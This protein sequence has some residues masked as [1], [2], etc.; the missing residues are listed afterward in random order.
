MS[1]TISPN[2]EVDAFAAA[3]RPTPAPQASGRPDV[4]AELVAKLQAQAAAEIALASATEKTAAA[5]LLA[6]AAAEA[7]TKIGEERARLLE[8]ERSLREQLADAQREAA[9]GQSAGG[10]RAL[11]IN[12]EIAG[13]E[14]MLAELQKDAP[15]IKSL[16]A[17]NRRRRVRRKSLE[18]SRG[19]HH[20]DERRGCRGARYGRRIR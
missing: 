11:K 16:Y 3:R 20:Q 8:Q 18:G 17:R 6:K 15:Q 19:V 10:E 7:E 9:S 5:S 4:V 12:A 1:F 13:L 14:K 2:L